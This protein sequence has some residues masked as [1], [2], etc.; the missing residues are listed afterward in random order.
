M[1]KRLTILGGAISLLAFLVSV[2]AHAAG[3]PLYTPDPIAVPAGKGVADI[4]KAIR[5]AGFDKGW[6]MREI[7][8]GHMQ[9]K[10][11]KTGR[12]DVNHVA[13]VDIRYDT[14]SIR[15]VYK[16]SQELDYDAGAKTI[17]K[18][19]NNWIRYLEKN[20][21]ANLGAY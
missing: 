11:T 7:G 5:K 9:A 12:K 16:D 21:R 4:K 6:D 14:R 1:L 3:Q 17:H 13:V 10:Y 15:I 20:I 19:Y 2:P 8:A 18:T